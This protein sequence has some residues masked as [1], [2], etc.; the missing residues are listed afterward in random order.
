M[1]L[2]PARASAFT[3]S[4]AV[5]FAHKPA[6]SALLCSVAL[7]QHW[8]QW[9]VLPLGLLP[10]MHSWVIFSAVLSRMLCH[11]HHSLLLALIADELDLIMMMLMMLMIGSNS[12]QEE[13]QEWTLMSCLCGM[14]YHEKHSH[15][16]CCDPHAAVTMPV[17]PSRHACIPASHGLARAYPDQTLLF[18][19]WTRA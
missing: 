17:V 4:A 3:P 6:R 1:C 19:S 16:D 5:H 14:R 8:R 9:Y 2:H 10:G 13:W 18:A 7:A 12:T 11:G 15:L